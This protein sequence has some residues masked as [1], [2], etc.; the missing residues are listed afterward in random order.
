[1]A[2]VNITRLLPIA[3]KYQS[4]MRTLHN[5][6]YSV[7][8]RAHRLSTAAIIGCLYSNVR[9]YYKKVTYFCKSSQFLRFTSR[10]TQQ[11]K[12]FQPPR[13]VANF[14]TFPLSCLCLLSISLFYNNYVSSSKC[15]YKRAGRGGSGG[16][17]GWE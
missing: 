2:S 10:S 1:M 14:F 16:V 7:Y 6:L 15:N 8:A 13:C 9:L 5:I 4:R 17:G 3:S 11:F 12:A